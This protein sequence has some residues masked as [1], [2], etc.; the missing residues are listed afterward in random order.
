MGIPITAAVADLRE[1][2]WL[3][4]LFFGLI[5]LGKSRRNRGAE[6]ALG[7]QLNKFAA[8]HRH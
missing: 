6:Q 3:R 4:A 7:K 1:D 5:D 2:E 8:I